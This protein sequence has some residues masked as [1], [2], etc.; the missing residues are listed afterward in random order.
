[1]KP[2]ATPFDGLLGLVPGRLPITK[3]GR[4]VVAGQSVTNVQKIG[5]LLGADDPASQELREAVRAKNKARSRKPNPRDDSA[6]AQE[7]RREYMRRYMAVWRAK[8]ENQAR[9]RQLKA[10]FNKRRYHADPE[11]ERARYRAWYAAHRDEILAR[12]K[13]KREAKRQAKQAAT[14]PTHD[15]RTVE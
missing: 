7:R 9:L 13:A 8:P 15:E 6:E 3:S 5:A 1:M 12:A 11:A 10:E 14:P 4:V 2:L